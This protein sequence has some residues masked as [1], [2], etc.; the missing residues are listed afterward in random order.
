MATVVVQGVFPAGSAV[1]ITGQV[2]AGDGH[3]V[4]GAPGG[5]FG[6]PT[7]KESQPVT[8]PGLPSAQRFG[9]PTFIFAKQSVA[10]RGLSSAQQFGT[11]LRT[12]QT[13]HVQGF[14]PYP[15]FVPSITGQVIS[16]DGHV[17]GGYGGPGWLFGHP[18]IHATIKVAVNG[19]LSAQQFGAVKIVQVV[20]PRSVPSARH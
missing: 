11:A 18:T 6:T 20:H 1:S 9:A 14:V 5:L 13:I 17:V 15:A 12:N 3:V 7:L 10:V 19:V 8:P 2:V 4:G 16:G